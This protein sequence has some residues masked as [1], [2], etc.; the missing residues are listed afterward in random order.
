MEINENTIGAIVEEA[1]QAGAVAAREAT[2]RPMIV[3]D[4]SSGKQWYVADGVCGFAWVNLYIKGLRKTSPL[5]RELIRLGF[6]KNDYE[7]CFQ[8]WVHGYDQSMELKQAYAGAVAETLR[9]YGIKAYAGSRM[10]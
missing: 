9:K 4:P 10:D 5:G 2:P 6:R 7:K 8:Y 3:S 1:A